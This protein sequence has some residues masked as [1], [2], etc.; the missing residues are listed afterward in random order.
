LMRLFLFSVI[1]RAIN[2]KC[3]TGIKP[4]FAYGINA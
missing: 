3:S 4:V 1:K 2:S